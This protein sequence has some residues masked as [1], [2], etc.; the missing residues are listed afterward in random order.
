VQVRLRDEV[1]V[2]QLKRKEEAQREYVGAIAAGHSAQ[3]LSEKR[4]DVFEMRV[5]NLKPNDKCQITIKCVAPGGAP[6]VLG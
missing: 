6:C 3:M 5:G 4:G 2:A 1:T